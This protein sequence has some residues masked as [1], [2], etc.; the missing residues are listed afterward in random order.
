M[1]IGFGYLRW[2]PYGPGPLQASQFPFAQWA[3]AQR[4]ETTPADATT[5]SVWSCPRCQEAKRLW[6][7]QHP[8]D[9]WARYE[10]AIPHT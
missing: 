9:P 1:P 8:D 4:G 2:G 3:V 5:E 10:S 6:I 7:Q